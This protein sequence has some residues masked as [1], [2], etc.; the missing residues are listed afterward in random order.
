MIYEMLGKD[1]TLTGRTDFWP[2]VIANIYERP[3]FGWGYFGFWTPANPPALS[4]AQAVAFKHNTWYI[5]VISNAHNALLEALLEIGVVGTTF[6]VVL[7]VRY[8]I[9]ATY[10]FNG[11]AKHLGLSF[12]MLLSGLVILGVSEVM[13]LSAQAI[14]TGLFF[15]V[16]M[17]CEKK[18]RQ[19]RRGALARK[20]AHSRDLGHSPSAASSSSAASASSSNVSANWSIRRD[21]RSDRWP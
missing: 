19:Y 5:A 2:E 12:L 14:F 1:P 11:P 21:D 6:F 8:V 16:G 17:A 10:C 18:M 3:L 13:L 9:A 7:I 20:S 4:I 15:V